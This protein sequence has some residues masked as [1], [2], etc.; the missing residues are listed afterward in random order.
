[1]KKHNITIQ[2]AGDSCAR[3]CHMIKMEAT[4]V[5]PEIAFEAEL[6]AA[7][8]RAE[9]GAKNDLELAATITA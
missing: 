8:E 7:L 3:S 6:M 4:T 9:S 2:A 5:D 1:M